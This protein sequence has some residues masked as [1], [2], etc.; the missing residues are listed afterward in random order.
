[1]E[2][3]HQDF[4]HLIRSMHISPFSYV[5]EMGQSEST[6]INEL[7]DQ[8]LYLNFAQLLPIEIRKEL[9]ELLRCEYELFGYD[10]YNDLLAFVGTL[11]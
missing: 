8:K 4:E 11:P 7:F 3:F 6:S 10:P 1:M 5:E 2:H 9:F